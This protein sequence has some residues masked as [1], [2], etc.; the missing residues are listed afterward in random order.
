[1]KISIITVC[2]N[3][4]ATIGDALRSVAEQTHADVEHII[5]DGASTDN[6]LDV[7]RANGGRVSLLLSEPDN[8][9]YD[10]M[11]KGIARASGDVVGFLNADDFYADSSVLESIARGFSDETV[12]VVYGDLCYVR[13]DQPQEIVRYWRSSD[14]RPGKFKH[15]WCPP[16]PTFFVRR[17]Y[18]QQA[19]GGYDTSFTLAADLE[20]IVRCLEVKRLRSVYLPQVLV[21]MR[22]GGETNRS[23]TNIIRQNREIL[24]ALENNGVKASALGFALGKLVSRARQFVTRPSA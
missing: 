3:A 5:I 6:T 9:I 7:I 2:R 19:G 18:Y 11:N 4:Q 14:Y 22:L 12:D 13:K 21:N 23:V 8:G 24:R 17:R 20:L 15:G 10:A 16:H 1:M